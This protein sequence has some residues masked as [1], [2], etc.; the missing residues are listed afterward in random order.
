MSGRRPAARASVN[1]HTQGSEEKAHVLLNTGV[2]AVAK[3]RGTLPRFGRRFA[4]CVVLPV[5]LPDV[6]FFVAIKAATFLVEDDFTLAARIGILVVVV[7]TLVE[8]LTTSLLADL[9]VNCSGT[10]SV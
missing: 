7:R 6:A 10:C 5:F 2:A 4:L 8:V 3:S 1:I 9:V